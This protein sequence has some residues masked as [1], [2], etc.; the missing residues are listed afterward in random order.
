MA[1]I[2]LYK[3]THDKRIMIIATGINQSIRLRN[4]FTQSTQCK[5]VYDHEKYIY[6]N[7]IHLAAAS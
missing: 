4:L 1:H 2:V 5:L 7:D 3:Q 6:C